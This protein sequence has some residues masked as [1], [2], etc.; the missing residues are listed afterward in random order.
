MLD[1]Y[2]KIQSKWEEE[3]L[4]AGKSSTEQHS[5]GNKL[6]LT[7]DNRDHEHSLEVRLFFLQTLHFKFTKKVAMRA[8]GRVSAEEITGST[9]K[10]S[11]NESKSQKQW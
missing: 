1:A 6:F 7:K 2:N 5:K 9:C 4:A 8:P 3:N 10:N 11:R